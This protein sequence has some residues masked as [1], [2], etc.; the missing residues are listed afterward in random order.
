MPKLQFFILIFF[1]INN[2]FGQH[3]NIITDRPG[4]TISAITVVKRD[5]QAEAGYLRQYEKITSSSKEYFYKHPLLTIK[6]GLSKRIELRFISEYATKKEDITTQ[7]IYRTGITNVELGAKVNFLKGAS[8]K[9]AISLIAHYSFHRLRTF[10]KGKD[11]IDGA[12]IRLA[13]LHNFTENFSLGYNAGIQWNWFDVPHLY[14]YTISPKFSFAERW[15]AFIELY[16]FVWTDRT[17]ENS[18]DGGLS[19]LINDN[20]KVDALL[21][22]G[23]TKPAPDKFFSIGASYRFNTGK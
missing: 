8:V 11:S 1:I 2:S 19:F 15:G 7:V 23:L 14:T 16:G 9:P 20:F 17:P 13:F 3:S 12:N 18:I 5:V 10:Y 6:F 4:E 21:G 22:F